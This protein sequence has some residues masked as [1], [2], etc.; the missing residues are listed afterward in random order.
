MPTVQSFTTPTPPTANT[1]AAELI[2]PGTAT[3]TG[4]VNPEGLETHYTIEYGPTTSYGQNTTSTNA[5]SETTPV[6]TGPINLN[7]L[8]ASTT[9]H[10]RLVAIN[11][12]GETTYGADMQF[13]T[14][15]APPVP[16]A[17]GN[18]SG[19]AAPQST[20]STSTAGVFPNL[21]AI[22]PVPATKEPGEATTPS[23]TKSL[24][25]AQKLTKALKQCKR[26]QRRRAPARAAK[27]QAHGKY[28]PKTKKK[29]KK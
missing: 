9:Y 12:L 10:Y 22:A 11:T 27:K 7:T 26:E 3:V 1:G 2:G 21:T 19:E 8:L 28:G 6:P 20:S 23:E 29:G 24:T 5:G 18:G 15:A 25:R 4:T 13:T 17:P 14:T 16:T